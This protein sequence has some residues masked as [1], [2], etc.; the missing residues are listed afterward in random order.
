MFMGVLPEIDRVWISVDN[1][2]YLW[3]YNR[4]DEYDVYDGLSEVIVSVSLSTP[5]A[6][7]FLESIKYILVVA[8]AVEV[9]ILALAF[10]TSN[11]AESMKLIPTSY[12]VSSDNTTMLK[13]MG[14]Q[15]GRIFM[16]GE[17]GNLYELDYHNAENSW[18]SLLGLSDSARYKCQKINHH[19]WNWR[20]VSM[21]PSLIRNFTM[22]EDPLVDICADNVRNLLY[23]I[24]SHGFLSVFALGVDY[25]STNNSIYQF[26][27]FEGIKKYVSER[28]Y[29]ESSL[30]VDGLKDLANI[31]IVGLF[32]L[33]ITESKKVHLMVLLSTGVRVYLRLHSDPSSSGSTTIST[34]RLPVSID[35]AFIRSPPP[36]NAINC[37]QPRVPLETGMESGV[38]P[39]YIPMQQLNIKRGYY[40]QGMFFMSL[41][42]NDS[43]NASTSDKLVAIY[44][45][46]TSHNV[47][48][49]TMR[50]GQA[51]NL[52]EAI[53]IVT[54]YDGGDVIYGKIYDIREKDVSMTTPLTA[55]LQTLT[56]LSAT[57]MSL[58]IQHQEEEIVSYQQG[59]IVSDSMV[60]SL[61]SAT[62]P[63]SLNPHGNGLSW[64]IGNHTQDTAII[65]NEF[66]CSH[67]PILNRNQ[68]RQFLCLTSNGIHILSKLT[69]ADLLVRLLSASHHASATSYLDEVKI[70]FEKYGA[71]QSS[72]ICIALACGL[73]SAAGNFIEQSLSA[74]SS[75]TSGEVNVNLANRAVFAM[76]KLTQGSSLQTSM[77]A[78]SLNVGAV[79]PRLTVR[80]SISYEYATSPVL[81]ALFTITSRILRPYWLRA[82][83]KGS[84]IADYVD[85]SSIYGIKTALE[86]LQVYFEDYHPLAIRGDPIIDLTSIASSNSFGR[87]SSSASVM[88]QLVSMSQQNLSH[89]NQMRQYVSN[90]E[91]A[92]LN[93]L[94][95]LIARSVQALDLLS[96]LYDLQVHREIPVPWSILAKYTFKSWVVSPN[97]HELI[98]KVIREVL[99]HFTSLSSS[100][101]KNVSV[102]SPSL[103]MNHYQ[104]IIQDFID[105]IS[106]N[107]YYYFSIGDRYA[108]DASVTEEEIKAFLQTHLGLKSSSTS[109]LPGSTTMTSPANLMLRIPSHSLR[110]R[111]HELMKRCV[112]QWTNAVEDW[113]SVD[114][115][116]PSNLPPAAS[117]AASAASA[118]RNRATND[119]ASELSR[120]CTS[121]RELGGY[122]RGG[123]VDVCLT[124]AKNFYPN[125][126]DS[127]SSL[128]PA[129]VGLY[130]RAVQPK[131]RDLDDSWEHEIYH[132]RP[133]L[134]DEVLHRARR[135]SYQCL[136]NQFLQVIHNMKFYPAIASPMEAAGS[137]DQPGS[138]SFS[139]FEPTLPEMMNRAMQLCNDDPLFHDILFETLL[140]ESPKHLIQMATSTFLENFLFL[141]DPLLLNR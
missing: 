17:D 123:I 52:R 137:S 128:N 2:L 12:V 136:V 84:Q 33:P 114:Y 139:A 109:T 66:V 5:K 113:K 76:Q 50:V 34:T 3:N 87:S 43:Q 41:S 74:W 69:P 119:Y 111:L 78:S 27:V 55:K 88:D 77:A 35:V 23:T 18:S 110:Q 83:T 97:V 92:I 53:S 105:K 7:I 126:E 103:S 46:L 80:G 20:V 63:S 96:Y 47:T 1:V 45:D 90:L 36:P 129:A 118:A 58:Q 108:Y 94:Y 85:M 29:L 134:S 60:K 115:V 101:A 9:S 49:E 32:A 26:N 28:I 72:T 99:L 62:V 122:C 31:S 8:T 73:P 39:S 117:S 48:P 51:P 120:I 75:S 44:E 38:L 91:D 95:R 127:S 65:R 71:V 133:N 57:P 98:K 131:P 68:H 19:Q 30:Q 10:D 37:S 124:A 81:D 64:G 140:K 24:S 135:E 93:A 82:M 16:A 130:R 89:E 70:F 138:P 42:P 79:D 14:T 21:L 116:M 54:D 141:K 22:G 132:G 6:G 102:S 4:P 86:R 112:E 104:V 67:I 13:V 100:A 106:K 61:P 11:T 107:C 15:L 40:S 121:L 59:V 56:S 25:Q 125:P